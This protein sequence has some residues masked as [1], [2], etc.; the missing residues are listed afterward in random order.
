MIHPKGIIKPVDE[1]MQEQGFPC[2][3]QSFLPAVRAFYSEENHL[4]AMPFNTS[5][6]VIFY[7]ADALEK[8]GYGENSF[9]RTWD[10]ME[11][12]ASKLKKAGFLVF[13]Q[14]LIQAGF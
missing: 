14:V 13:T 7:N 9:P 12:L 3:K 1:L 10:E 2:P 11:I 6:P 8:L 4:L 5:I